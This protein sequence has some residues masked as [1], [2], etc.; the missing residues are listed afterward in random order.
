MSDVFSIVMLKARHPNLHEI[1]DEEV[2]LKSTDSFLRQDGRLSTDWTR[3]SQRLRGDVVLETAGAKVLRREARV[4][5]KINLRFHVDHFQFTNTDRLLQSFL[6]F[7]SWRLSRAAV[8]TDAG[9]V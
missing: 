5:I 8:I 7:E 9:R 6:A 3:E 2:V 4:S 1:S